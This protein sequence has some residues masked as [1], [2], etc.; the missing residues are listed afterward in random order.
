RRSP[1][2]SEFGFGLANSILIALVRLQTAKAQRLYWVLSKF[3][4]RRS[5]ATSLLLC[6]ETVFEKNPEK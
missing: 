4:F 6:A 2:T 5:R 1:A 3:D